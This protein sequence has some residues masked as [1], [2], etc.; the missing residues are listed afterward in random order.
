[1]SDSHAIPPGRQPVDLDAVARDDQ[2]LDLLGAGGQPD[3][4]EPLIQ[5]LYAWRTELSAD[6]PEISVRPETPRSAVGRARV[7]GASANGAAPNAKRLNGKKLNGVP[8]P[9][10]A[11]EAELDAPDE[12]YPPRRQRGRRRAIVAASLI[13][14]SSGLGG[15]AAAAADA[16]PG[17]ALWPITKA[18]FAETAEDKEAAAEARKAL[19]NAR[20]ALADGRVSDAERYLDEAERKARA[21]D[22][23]TADELREE[24]GAVRSKI[25]ENESG[26]SK[27]NQPDEPDDDSPTGSL[28]T[29]PTLPTPDND[30]ETSEPGQR[31][32]DGRSGNA[33]D[34]ERDTDNRG[35][36]ATKGKEAETSSLLIDP[37]ILEGLEP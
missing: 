21:T 6:L 34:G 9:A 25:D 35:N 36:D 32:R 29:K 8:R 16:E 2:L 1:M 19:R 3:S 26:S 22:A 15:V 13:G 28:P 18:I 23:Q 11:P 20:E 17:S 10:S 4:R 33:K 27:P 14:L 7:N 31:D 30:T 24:A 5:A 37:R 12:D